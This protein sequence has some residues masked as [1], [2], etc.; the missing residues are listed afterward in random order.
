[1]ASLPGKQGHVPTQESI[2]SIIDLFTQEITSK[3]LQSSG[4]QD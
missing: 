4:K 2:G 3:V 1:M